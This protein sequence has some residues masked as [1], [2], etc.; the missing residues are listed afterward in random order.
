[1]NKKSIILIGM[2]SSGKSTLGVLLAKSLGYSFVD[3]D[4]L[5]QNAEGKLLHELIE[6][7]GADGFLEVENRVNLNI[8][9][10]GAIIATGGSVVYCEEAMEHL[11][12]LGKVV[13]LYVPFEEMKRRLGDFSH[14]GV[15]MRKGNTLAEMY[16]ERAP[17]YEKYADVTVDVCADSLSASIDKICETVGR[18]TLASK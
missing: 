3:S 1:M 10:K 11:R 5:I 7:R 4:L 18:E 2:P 17:L 12:T 8:S 16:A 6:E 9:V 14:R 13:Y 15:V